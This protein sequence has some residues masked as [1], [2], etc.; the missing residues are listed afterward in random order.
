LPLL[1]AVIAFGS[2]VSAGSKAAERDLP[3]KGEN[4]G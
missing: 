1:A 2:L 4:D 3:G